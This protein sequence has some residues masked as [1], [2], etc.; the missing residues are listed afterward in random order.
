[1]RIHMVLSFCQNPLLG[2]VPIFAN[3]VW[4]DVDTDDTRPDDQQSDHKDP[5]LSLLQHY[6]ED[7]FGDNSNNDEWAVIAEEFE[8]DTG[9]VEDPV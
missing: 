1:M 9:E 5:P 7:R 4:L 3:S 6:K 2:W 8:E